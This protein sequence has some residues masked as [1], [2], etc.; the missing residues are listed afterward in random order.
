MIATGHRGLLNAGQLESTEAK[1]DQAPWLAFLPRQLLNRLMLPLGSIT[2]PQIAKLAREIGLTAQVPTDGN[3]ESRQPCALSQQEW[4]AWA[5]ARVPTGFQN[6]GP[7]THAKTIAIAEHG[8]ILDYPIGSQ[9]TIESAGTFL[10]RDFDTSSHTLHVALPGEGGESEV[11]VEGLNW[12][13]PASGKPGPS[14]KV[15]VHA[16]G[17]SAGSTTVGTLFF[18]L[19]NEG[20]LLLQ[21]PMTNLFRGT[22]LIFFAGKRILGA[23]WVS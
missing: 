5:S 12:I 22:P 18:H 19:E 1:D 21:K 4:L 11:T 23:G 3:A 2:P 7:I 9:V 16:L 17:A 6:P 14:A 15:E 20:R 10:A 13:E 8:G